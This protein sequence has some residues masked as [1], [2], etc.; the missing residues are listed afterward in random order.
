M[1]IAYKTRIRKVMKALKIIDS[2]TTYLFINLRSFGFSHE[3]L[4]LPIDL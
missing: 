3:L 1:V 2:K 4:K